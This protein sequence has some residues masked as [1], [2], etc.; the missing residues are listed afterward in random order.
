MNSG[1]FVVG[2]EW[3]KLDGDVR[4]RGL[5]GPE[6]VAQPI[7]VGQ[8]AGIKIGVNRMGEFG[9]AGAVVSER[10]ETDHGAAG[11]PIQWN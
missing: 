8:S 10:K 1:Q 9:L 4:N 6:A 7:E 11:L 5:I 3:R 2:G